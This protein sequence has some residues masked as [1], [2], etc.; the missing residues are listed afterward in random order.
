MS[1][2]QNIFMIINFRETF[3]ITCLIIHVV[4]DNILIKALL[5]KK[6]HSCSLLLTIIK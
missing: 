1:S 5:K 3:F 4:I 2:Q 6:S